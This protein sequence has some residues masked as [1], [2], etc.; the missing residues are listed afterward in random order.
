MYMVDDI[1]EKWKKPKLSS[2]Q[3]KKCKAPL[4]VVIW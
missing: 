2:L 4:G 1:V 3:N